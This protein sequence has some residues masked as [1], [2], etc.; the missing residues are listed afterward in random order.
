[1]LSLPNTDQSATDTD[2]G[3]AE[4]RLAGILSSRHSN[5]PLY[6]LI[7]DT[8]LED[9]DFVVYTDARLEAETT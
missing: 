8:D 5:S 1:M 4:V 3:L 2:S 9:I 7:I 6:K